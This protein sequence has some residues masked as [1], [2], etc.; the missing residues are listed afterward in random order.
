MKFASLG[1]LFAA[2][3]VACSMDRAVA[4]K[5]QVRENQLDDSHPGLEK[6]KKKKKGKKKNCPPCKNECTTACAISDCCKEYYPDLEKC[7]ISNTTMASGYLK[8]S[9]TDFEIN[10]TMDA[11]LKLVNDL[12][13]DVGSPILQASKVLDEKALVDAKDFLDQ[14]YNREKGRQKHLVVRMDKGDELVKV[15]GEESVEKLLQVFYKYIGEESTHHVSYAKF[16]RIEQ[17]GGLVYPYHRD[18][19]TAL[20]LMI[21]DDYKGGNVVYLT[22]DGSVEIPT[23]A[24][25]VLVHGPDNVHATT[26]TT[27]TKYML[28]L[29]YD[30][31]MKQ[32]MFD[33][34][35]WMV[36]R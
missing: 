8:E 18:G 9:E 34:A 33:G 5:L 27:G 28:V 16:Y 7:C 25:L 14:A 35:S 36:S 11:L 12:N 32:H 19:S 2:A 1:V 20:T 26:P 15:I 13:G 29:I 24:G 17:E 4:V 21:N 30:K 3:L 31:R 6:K 22:G 10:P 23:E